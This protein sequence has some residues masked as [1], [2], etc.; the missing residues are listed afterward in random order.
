MRQRPDHMG[1]PVLPVRPIE[2][3]I[4]AVWT[5]ILGVAPIGIQDDFFGLGGDSLR[6]VR[7]AVRL[8]QVLGREVPP[9]IMFGPHTIAHQAMLLGGDR[10]GDLPPQGRRT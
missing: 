2:H 1:A 7:L 9:Q 6:A 5:E 3:Q 8:E 10:A 4:A